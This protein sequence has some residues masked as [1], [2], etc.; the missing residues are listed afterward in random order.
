MSTAGEGHGTPTRG[1]PTHCFLLVRQRNKR[2]KRNNPYRSRE[3]TSPHESIDENTSETASVVYD[4]RAQDVLG[5]F[6]PAR[7][8]SDSPSTGLSEKSPLISYVSDEAPESGMPPVA[9][10]DR[11]RARTRSRC[12]APRSI[13]APNGRRACC[14]LRQK[15]RNNGEQP[16]LLRRSLPR[17][18]LRFEIQAP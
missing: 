3:C 9:V 6:G 4:R 10:R 14:S 17:R 15:L 1:R 8:G 18:E 2:T 12:S 11:F 5:V 16:H 7:A 13:K